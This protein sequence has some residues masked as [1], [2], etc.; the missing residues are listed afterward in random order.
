MSDDIV[1]IHSAFAAAV[2]FLE[3][4]KIPQGK[5]LLQNAANSV[6]GK[7]L[8]SVARKKYGV[9]TINVV[10]RRE[11]INELKEIG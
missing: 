11:V 5:Y 9:K 10:R 2:G 7:E 1:L 3:D 6:L 4:L 8:I